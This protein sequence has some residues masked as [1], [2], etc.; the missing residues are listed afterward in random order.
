[1]AATDWEAAGRR[2]SVSPLYELE[3]IDLFMYSLHSFAPDSERRITAA[4]SIDDLDRTTAGC[5]RDFS[6][7][8][9]LVVSLSFGS[10]RQ[11]ARAWVERHRDEI[12]Y[13]PTRL[14]PIAPTV[15]AD[16]VARDGRVELEVQG[17][18]RWDRCADAL[19]ALAA[20]NRE[21]AQVV[22]QA[23]REAVVVGLTLGQESMAE[24]LP[25]FVEALDAVDPALLTQLLSDVDPNVARRTW[26]DRLA[27][28]P[29][30]RMAVNLLIDRALHG[31]PAIREVAAAFR[32]S[33]DKGS[34]NG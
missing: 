22:L 5:W 23:S 8:E 29:G 25:A 17:G 19:N 13:M 14:V 10:D 15:A 21:S 4:L 3:Q 32:N 2:L 33:H 30:E 20:V 27:G 31:G 11:P 28:S 7:I 6:G 12:R 18:L 1:L 34:A 26:H 9:R 16:V 24:N